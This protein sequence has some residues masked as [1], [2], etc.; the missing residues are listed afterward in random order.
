MGE[1]AAVTVYA[2]DHLAISP[3][4]SSFPL[5]WSGI[6]AYLRNVRYMPE[7]QV[8]GCPCGS[9]GPNLPALLVLR[10][11]NKIAFRQPVYFVRE[12]RHEHSSPRQKNVWVM[13]LNFG[14][15]P[16]P[17]GEIEGVAEVGESE[18]LFEVM[19]VNDLPATAEL[20]SKSLQIITFQ[21]R[22]PSL[23]R[24]TFSIGQFT[25]HD[26]PLVFSRPA[27]AA[28]PCDLRVSLRYCSIVRPRAPAGFKL[29]MYSSMSRRSLPPRYPLFGV[30]LCSV[31]AALYFS[32]A[33]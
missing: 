30:F 14:N 27:V 6:A 19:F 23:T 31:L 2:A 11:E 25:L 16:Q 12:D 22:N 28:S 15:F 1:M 17:V 8:S 4:K 20:I 9:L 5:T 3:E 18:F 21:C 13:T 10:C 32:R 24:D 29:L 7:L 33:F 26:K